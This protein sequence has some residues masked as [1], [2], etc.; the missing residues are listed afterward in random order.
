MAAPLQLKRGVESARSGQTPGAG[1]LLYTTDKKKVYVGD[2]STVGGNPIIAAGGIIAVKGTVDL[3]TASAQTI[4]DLPADA[5]VLKTYLEIGTPS[6]ASTTV[7]VGDTT[8]GAASYMA[9]TENDPE[10]SATFISDNVVHNGGTLRT[11]KAT[12]AT[13]GSVGS[14]TCIVEYR[15][16]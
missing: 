12:V 1:E 14:G 11:I 13:P 8:N 4:A 5:D 2:G 16:A 3:T 15:T 7:T 6:D 9:S 10:L